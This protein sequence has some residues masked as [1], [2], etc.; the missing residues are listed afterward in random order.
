MTWGASQ[1]AD[2]R[3]YLR[4][5]FVPGA[6]AGTPW[7]VWLDWQP[8]EEV[9]LPVWVAVTGRQDAL[10]FDWPVESVSFTK[11]E[12]GVYLESTR[13]GAVQA[14]L[15]GN[16]VQVDEPLGQ[17]TLDHGSGMRTV[18]RDLGEIIVRQGDQV[19]LG[20]ILGR[21]GHSERLF[22]ALS[23]ANRLVDPTTRV[24]SSPR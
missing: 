16:A 7:A 13:G 18:Y 17:V 14:V 12:G 15:A 4:F 1:F 21:V 8:Q 20:Q 10:A 2:L 6:A 9:A 3:E 24:R 11:A 23:L 22:F 5:V 19:A